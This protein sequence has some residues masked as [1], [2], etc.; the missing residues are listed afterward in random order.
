MVNTM[1]LARATSETAGSAEQDVGGHGVP[2]GLDEAQSG[3]V[4]EV[5]VGTVGGMEHD[6]MDLVEVVDLFVQ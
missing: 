6:G 1:N 5:N 4:G 3:M 2:T